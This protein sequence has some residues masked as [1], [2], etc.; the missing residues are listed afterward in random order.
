M[1]AI[2]RHTRHQSG[3]LGG[4]GAVKGRSPLA[5]ARSAAL[6]GAGAA[7]QNRQAEGQS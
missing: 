7:K 5:G 6:E 1:A 2:L 4:T 3:L